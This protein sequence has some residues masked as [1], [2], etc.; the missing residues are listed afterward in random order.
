MNHVVDANVALA[1]VIA[2][3][4]SDRAQALWG[5]WSDSQ[6]VVFAPDL[7]AYE[8]TSALRKAM[9]ITGIGLS[10]AVSRLEVLTQLGVR[11]VP[12]TPALH[13]SAL[14]WADRLGQ[15]VAYDA[16]YVAL[17]E[18]LDCDFWTADRRLVGRV[19]PDIPWVRWVGDEAS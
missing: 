7:W 6:A 15:T 14:R 19:S 12:P 9:V 10:D 1:L 18:F 4:Y 16:H 11:L 5:G 8:L 17:A 3:P 2:T 13:R